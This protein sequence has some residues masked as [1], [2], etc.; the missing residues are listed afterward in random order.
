MDGHLGC[1]VE[2][3]E[4]DERWIEKDGGV[5][6]CDFWLMIGIDGCDGHTYTIASY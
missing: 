2:K 3:D 1:R 4:R 5:Y 6:M